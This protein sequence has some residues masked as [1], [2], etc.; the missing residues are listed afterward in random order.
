[1]PA[2]LT[3]QTIAGEIA[4][5][6]DTLI[7]QEYVNNKELLSIKCGVCK[8]IYAQNYSSYYRGFHHGMCAGK[9]EMKKNGKVT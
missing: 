2:K 6:G 8:E 4:K 7:S 3:V 1:M 9:F 5:E